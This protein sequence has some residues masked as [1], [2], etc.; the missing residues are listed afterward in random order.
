MYKKVFA[1]RNGPNKHKIHLWTDEGYEQIEWVNYAYKECPKEDA[2]HIGLKGEP[3]YKTKYY[4]YNP[5]KKF[6]PNTGK[7]EFDPRN[8][9]HYITVENNVQGYTPEYYADD[10][11][12]KNA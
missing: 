7:N 11:Q 6:N 8:D 4:S 9:E 1:E 3:L 12:Y 5:W 2:T 10:N